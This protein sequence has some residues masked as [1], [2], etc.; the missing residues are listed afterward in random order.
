MP[1]VSFIS[2]SPVWPQS[3]L[4]HGAVGKQVRPDLVLRFKDTAA[5]GLNL[6]CCDLGNLWKLCP[7]LDTTSMGEI[8]QDS[9]CLPGGPV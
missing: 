2:D 8:H 3:L 6:S 7:T 4:L 5:V 1:M 9:T